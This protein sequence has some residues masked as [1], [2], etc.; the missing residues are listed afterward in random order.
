MPSG[1]T[2][3]FN[4]SRKEL[5]SDSSTLYKVAMVPTNTSRA[6]KE[7]ISA[8]PIFQS[9]PNGAMRGSIFLPIMPA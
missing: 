8:M 6:A 4:L 9:N 7:V 3:A 1:R 5:L 2:A